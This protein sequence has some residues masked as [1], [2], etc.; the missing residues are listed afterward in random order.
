LTIA[1]LFRANCTSALWQQFGMLCD[2]IVVEGAEAAYYEEQP[3]EYVH[4]TRLGTNQ[5]YFTI[6]LEYGPD[7]ERDG[8]LAGS[9]NL[10]PVIR[11]FRRG[12]LIT[13]HHLADNI[14]DD[15]SGQ[16]S[17]REPLR[18]FFAREL[19]LAASASPTLG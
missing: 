5:S 11:H 6:T 16:E 4:E 7:H 17:H 14:D 15:W 19:V 18:E 3:V 1:V 2:L 10:H 12:T 9:A 13:E 8:E